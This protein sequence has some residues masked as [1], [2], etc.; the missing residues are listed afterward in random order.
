M[1]QVLA[2]RRLDVLIVSSLPNIAYLSGFA[3]SA[4]LLAVTA[5]RL[6]L[7]VDFRYSA[8][9]DEAAREGRL[10]PAV[11]SMQIAAAYDRELIAV[12][13]ERKWQRI[14]FEAAHVSVSRF[15]YWRRQFDEQVG[16]GE[17]DHEWIAVDQA[18]ESAR[19][20][21]DAHEIAIMREAGRRLS[22]VAREVIAEVV[23]AGRTESEIAADI[24]WRLRRAGFTRPAFDTI[25]AAGPNGALPHAVPTARPLAAGDLVVLDFGGVYGGY[26]VDLTRTVGV[27]RVAS[28]RRQLFDAVAE[29]HAAALRVAGTPGAVTGDV[30]DAA[31]GVLAAYGLAE[32]FGHGTG[33]GLGLEVHEAPR[34][35]RRTAEHPGTEPLAAGMIFTIEPGAYV[36]GLGG[37]RIED[38]VLVTEGGCELLTDA[39]RAWCEC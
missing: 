5:D 36:P 37:V 18:V 22:G 35:T 25:V 20:R 39:P 27:G 19:L 17:G 38:D 16:E 21:K 13:V 33:H 26:C 6:Y 9:V 4:G 11:E 34:V 15:D 7:M 31:R 2:D 8:A 32:R 3:G 23:R 24:D 10:A 29:A 14:G 28:D 12:L 1:A 30:D